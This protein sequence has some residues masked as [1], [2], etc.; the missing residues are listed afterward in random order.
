MKRYLL[1]RLLLLA[2]TLLLVSMLA[3]WLQESA[4]GDPVLRYLKADQPEETVAEADRQLRARAHPRAVRELGLDL[5][6]FYLGL[7]PLSLPDTLHRILPLAS[8]KAFRDLCLETGDPRAVAGWFRALDRT[9][10]ALLEHPDQT[11]ASVGRA[12]IRQ[13]RVTTTLQASHQLLSEWPEETMPALRT[14]L[15]L[16]L[17]RPAVGLRWRN[18]LPAL[19]GHGTANRYHRW[20]T[21]FFSGQSQRSWQDGQPVWRK[22]RGAARWTLLMNGIALLLAYAFSIPLGVWMASRTGTR[23]EGWITFLLYAFYSIPAFWLGTLLLVFLT[24]PAY[25]LHWFPAVGLGDLPPGADWWEV[26]HIRAAHLVLPVFCLTYGSLAYLTRQVRNAMLRELSQDYVRTAWAKGLS[27]RRVL[28][29]H[30]FRNARFPLI[31]LLAQVLPAA[32]AGSVAIEVIFTIPGMGR[33]TWA[34]IMAQDW[35]VVY[36]VLFLAAVLTLAGSLV[37][38]ILY[39]LSD[40]RVRLAK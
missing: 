37:A 16:D 40:P 30:A 6:A 2:P 25:G 14:A 1:R 24:S 23:G 21:G 28:W 19:D 18:V 27:E 7:R 13:W 11:G 3:F 22:I 9:E 17:P 34:A 31:T 36:G 5:P 35:P 12:L 29:G 10:Q 38:D 20:M 4:P 15:A 26:L 33:L 39:S 32:L 8:R